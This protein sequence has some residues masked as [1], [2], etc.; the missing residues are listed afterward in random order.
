[1]LYSTI[2]QKLSRS[3]WYHAMPITMHY[4]L[5]PRRAKIA[6]LISNALDKGDLRPHLDVDT[7]VG[8]VMSP[9]IV[10]RLTGS[11][12]KTPKSW[13]EHL[14]GSLLDGWRS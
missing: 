1:M 2:F 6:R 7:A 10:R 9:I 13:A 3:R 4:R 11:L 5:A 8:M 12:D 14:V